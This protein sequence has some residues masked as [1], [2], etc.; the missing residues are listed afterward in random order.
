MRKF[1]LVLF[2][3]LSLV[4]EAKSLSGKLPDARHASLSERSLLD[5]HHEGEHNNNAELFDEQD[6]E[7][8]KLELAKLYKNV[9]SSFAKFELAEFSPD[10]YQSKIRPWLDQVEMTLEASGLKELKVSLGLVLDAESQIQALELYSA[11]PELQSSELNDF[12]TE[13]TSLILAKIPQELSGFRFILDAQYLSLRRNER[14]EQHQ[15][16][17]QIYTGAETR[18][19]EPKVN[20]H[21]H[22][23]A[24]LIKPAYFSEPRQ[25]QEISFII[26]GER[27]KE[28]GL[29]Y[30]G[31]LIKLD[32]DWMILTERLR[33]GSDIFQELWCLERGSILDLEANWDALLGG[34]TKGGLAL[35]AAT[36]AMSSAV[37]GLL[38]L[39]GSNLER[40]YELYEGQYLELVYEGVY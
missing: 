18:Q 39:V 22:Y 28:S 20:Y 26:S 40:S 29:I 24:K 32:D 6:L 37:L 13:L 35:I 3:F 33:L 19:L 25:G 23:K 14:L 38:S 36:N 2:C 34:A 5:M 16:Y 31:H 7:L 1:L 21:E 11:D 17:I 12:V 9:D 8:A 30:K 4:D 10:L 27:G 15:D